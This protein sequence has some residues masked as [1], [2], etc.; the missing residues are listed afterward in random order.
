VPETVLNVTSRRSVDFFAMS[1]DLP[2]AA[3]RVRAEGDKIILE[4]SRTNMTAMHGLIKRV[5]EVLREAGFPIVLT[6]LFDRKSLTHQCGTVR[7][8]VDPASAP[9]DTFG[10]AFDV[11]NLFVVDASTLVTSA[12]VNP[13]LTVAALSMRTAAHIRKAELCAE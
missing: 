3:N 10:R 8:G 6:R 12:A 9:L 1:E 13:S 11:Q 7:I 2:Q 5:R 4:W